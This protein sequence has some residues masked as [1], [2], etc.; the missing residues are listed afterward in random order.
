MSS[1]PGKGLFMKRN[2]ATRIIA[3]SAALAVITSAAASCGKKNSSSKQV[4]KANEVLTASYR[5]EAIDSD[6][7]TNNISGISKLGDSGK[8]LIYGNDYENKAPLLYVTDEEFLNFDKLDIDLGLQDYDEAFITTSV[9]PDG[10]IFILATT[11][12]YGDF[13]MPDYDD[14]NFDYEN[15][16]YDAMDAA[17]ETSFKLYTADTD[18]NILTTADMT[19]LTGDSDDQNLGILLPI[20]SDKALVGISDKYMIID[21][22][23]KKVAD[24]DAGDMD[25]INYSAMSYDGKLAIAGYGNNTSLIR[26]IDPETL[27]PVGNDVTF[28]NTGSFNLNSIFTGSEEFPLYFTTNSGLY[29]LDSEGSY[30]EIINWQDSDISQYGA[31]AILPLASGDFIAAINDYD[32]GDSGLYRLTKRDS[33]ELENTSVITVGMLY[34]DWQI[35][36]QVSKFN[37]SNSGFRIK[38]VNYGEYDSYDEE[39]GEQTASGTEQLKKDIISG[40]APDML[41][42]YDYSVISSLASKGLY[43]DL[44]EFMNKDSELTRD[45]FMPNILEASTIN[46][47]ILS[48]SPEFLVY[49]F[50]AKTKYCD[51]ENWTFDD[52]VNT[53]ESLPDGMKLT[54]SDSKESIFSM[55]AYMSSSFIDYEKG[56]CSFDSPEFIQLLEFANRFPDADDAI[57]WETATEDEMEQY[58]NDNETAYLND[59]ALLNQVY[60][61]DFREY[62]RERTAIFNDDIT[63]VGAP[64]TDGNGATLGFETSFAI[65]QDSPSKDDCWNFIKSFFTEDYYAAMS[66]GFPSI[67]SEFEKKADEAME[68]PY[69]L[70]PETNKKEYYDNTYFINN[71]EITIDPLTQEER[72]FLVNYIKGV[73][74]LSGSY[75]NDFYDIINEEST[76]YFKG[77]K[78]A[79]EAADII[80]NRISILVSEQS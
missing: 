74:K 75:T 22:S 32:T 21:S 64:S 44:G 43:A 60:M 46:D 55:F 41:V 80:Q 11:N 76:A 77:E 5:S 53:Y 66:N 15:F 1:A 62:A 57:D 45:A 73:T 35:N 25:W 69:Y 13:Q 31:G 50:A 63:L 48:I 29:S 12:D 14:P 23:A 61:S 79:Q 34:D 2:Y 8:I 68:R 65:L 37:K 72:D 56:T 49:T 40:N 17:R 20:S 47:K 70:D 54:A 33:S 67:T 30:N 9:A 24:V 16:D 58:W 10:T 59:K 51:K 19:D 39:S 52:M 42:T 26:Y 28:D 6:V 3:L 18:G 7:D 4:K 27:K 38:T 71:E 78:T 36:T